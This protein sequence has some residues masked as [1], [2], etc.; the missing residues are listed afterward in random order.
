MLGLMFVA[1]F[2][3]VWVPG[4]IW[5]TVWMNVV[6][7]ESVNL[8]TSLVGSVPHIPGDI[9]KAVA[10]AGVARAVTPKKAYNGEPDG[11]KWA[12]WRIP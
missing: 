11:D 7:G 10:A 6:G 4:L 3:L 1:D 12:T 8:I 2:V 5:R 9:L